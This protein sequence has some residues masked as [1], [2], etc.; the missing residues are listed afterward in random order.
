MKKIGSIYRHY[1]NRK[2]IS[3]TVIFT[4]IYAI[5]PVSSVMF[6]K[7]FL[8]YIEG[9][10]NLQL[11]IVS[12]V[13]YLLLSFLGPPLSQIFET[14]L[15]EFRLSYLVTSY[16][17][18]TIDLP[19]ESTISEIDLTTNRN[20]ELFS[21]QSWK[22]YQRLMK[23]VPSS[24]TIISSLVLIAIMNDN[25]TRV[26]MIVMTLLA[27]LVHYF[28]GKIPELN[29]FLT[30]LC[31]ELS[32]GKRKEELY[33]LKILLEKGKISRSEFKQILTMKQ[34]GSSEQLFKSIEN[35]LD[36][37]FFVKRDQEKYGLS[38]LSIEDDTYQLATDFTQFLTEEYKKFILDIIQTGLERSQKYPQEPLTIGEK[39]S[40]KDA[41]RL[42]NWDKDESSTVYGYKVKHGTC[43][44]FVT[45]H[46]D[47]DITETTQYQDGFLS[48]KV[49]HWYSRSNRSFKSKEVADIMQ[50]NQTG[51]ALHLF[52]KKE[53]GEGSDFYYLGPVSY[54]E[55]SATET[56]MQDGKTPVVTMNFELANE[57]SSAL[58]DYL[59]KK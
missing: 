57:V 11:T 7:G 58:Y 13:F 6:L 5:L 45:Y 30:F 47:D 4:L 12:S 22:G 3:L 26:F 8:N 53:D 39:Y 10:S 15:A 37:N 36:Y 51:L 42:L 35:C 49:F 31:K 27:L 38:A 16:F 34:L 46:K 48:N 24:L 28:N 55:D 32:N 2:L 17:E 18:K 25:L 23:L 59:T 40:R 20:G 41:V 33:L 44:I 14:E 1:S 54:L 19:I 29:S 50:S 9:V 52:V 43:P 56:R 21:A